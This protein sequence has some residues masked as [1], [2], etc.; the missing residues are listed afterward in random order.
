MSDVL[1]DLLAGERRDEPIYGVVIGVVTNNKD[2]EK[3]GRVRV[4]LPWLADSLQTGW[5]RVATP[6]AGAEMGLFLLPEVDDEVLVAF[7]HGDIRFPFVIGSLWSKGKAPPEVN[8]DGLNNLRLLKSRSGHTIR[9]N[10]KEG[11]EKLE[12]IDK[13]GKNSLVFDAVKNTLTI[14]ADA[15]IVIKAANGKLTLSGN[16]VE[17]SS[18]ADL[19]LKAGA[20]VK[21]EASGQMKLQGATIELN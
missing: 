18:Q 13:T 7:D 3:L 14:S 8:A 16:G 10:D 11:E 1:Y 9:L 21:V 5:A 12:I 19:A 6:M 17:I 20:G 4:R 2:P 15:D